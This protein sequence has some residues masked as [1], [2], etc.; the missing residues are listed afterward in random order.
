MVVWVGEKGMAVSWAKKG[1]AGL[2]K[3]M[4]LLIHQVTFIAS[5]RARTLVDGDRAHVFFL[6]HRLGR[7]S[8]STTG[9]TTNLV[10]SSHGGVQ[11]SEITHHAFV[12]VLLIRVHCLSM[13]PEVIESW[14]LFWT[15]TR[16]GPFA[17]MFSGYCEKD[18]RGD[19]LGMYLMCLARCSLREKTM[20]HSPY[21]RHWKV[22][23]GAWRFRLNG[24]GDRS[25][26]SSM[27]IRGG[28]RKKRRTKTCL[29][30]EVPG[31]FK[32]KNEK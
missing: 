13:L 32:N 18:E 4:V 28:R 17:C 16:E 31:L 22:F 25:L 21:P 15:V 6:D 14:K 19:W 5:T 30:L 3:G 26:S 11:R 1:L 27:V 10:R 20:R 24:C 12:Q 9:T 8:S 29:A 7:C 2:T 23:A